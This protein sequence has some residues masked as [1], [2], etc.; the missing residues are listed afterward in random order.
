MTNALDGNAIA[1]P[2]HELFGAEMTTTR[3][4]CIGCRAVSHIAELT[5]YLLGPGIVAR[6]RHC[7]SVNMVLVT[8][9]GVTCLDLQG[10]DITAEAGA[11]VDRSPP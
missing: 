3:G 7:G 1:G 6:C 10:L 4:A 9:R 2:L 11:R 8:I 5:V